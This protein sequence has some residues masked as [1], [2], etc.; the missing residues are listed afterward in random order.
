MSPS[1]FGREWTA[2]GAAANIPVY[3]IKFGVADE[4]QLNEIARLS[5]GRVFDGTKDLVRAFR[6]ARGYN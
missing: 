6:Q 1:Q 4:R 5:S 2:G 3:S